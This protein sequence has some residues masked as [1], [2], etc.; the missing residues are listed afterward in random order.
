MDVP[1]SGLL[2]LPRFDN[3]K[4]GAFFLLDKPSIGGFSRGPVFEFLG[5]LSSGGGLTIGG[6]FACVGLVHGTIS[7][8]TGG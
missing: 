8:E 4:I 6:R 2:R 1:S 7:D 3:R 5:A